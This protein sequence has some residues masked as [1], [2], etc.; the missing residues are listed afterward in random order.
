LLKPASCSLWLHPARYLRGTA[1]PAANSP[2]ERASRIAAAWS[3]G[4][5]SENR[6]SHGI[7]NSR[8]FWNPDVGLPGS[9]RSAD[10]R[11]GHRPGQVAPDG[12]WHALAGHPEAGEGRRPGQSCNRPFPPIRRGMK[13]VA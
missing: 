1:E 12:T 2:G 7:N 3:R 11:P 8:P 6:S 10:R 9:A 4:R 5:A 13:D